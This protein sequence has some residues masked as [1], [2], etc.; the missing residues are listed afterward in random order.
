VNACVKG[1]DDGEIV[2][3]RSARKSGGVVDAGEMEGNSGVGRSFAWFTV[4]FAP[5]LWGMWFVGKRRPKHK[6]EVE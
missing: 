3:C 1:Q 6:Q 5:L 2:E 4:A